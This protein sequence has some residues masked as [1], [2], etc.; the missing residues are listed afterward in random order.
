MHEHPA[1][2]DKP[3]SREIRSLPADAAL[4]AAAMPTAA[5]A[6]AEVEIVA[7]AMVE[8]AEIV[9]AAEIEAAKG[10][11]DEDSYGGE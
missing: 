9:A 4:G 3:A 2:A 5:A 7:A 10:K 8:V 1:T 6:T 11:A